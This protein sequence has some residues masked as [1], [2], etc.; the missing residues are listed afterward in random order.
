MSDPLSWI[1]EE[2]SAWRARGLERSLDPKGPSVDGRIWSY[3]RWLVNFASNDYLSL[4]NDPR[5]ALAAVKAVEHDGWGSGSSPLVS[6]WR[7]IHEELASALANLE[8]AQA[9]VLFPT[10]YAANLAAI[11]SLVSRGD[12][13]YSDALN[14]ACIIDAARLSRAEVRI[15]PHSRTDALEE[16]LEADRG[17]FRRILIAVEGVYSMDGDEAH[18]AELAELADRFGAILL[19][20]EAHAT[21]LLG[22]NG[23]IGGVWR[24]GSC[25]RRHAFKGSWFHRRLCRGFAQPDRLADQ[26][27]T[28]ADFFDGSSACS[29][30]R[31][32]SGA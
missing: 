29:V 25:S 8:R 20:D 5:V 27:C 28:I 1:P 26:S 31:C 15:F 10:G 22:E 9:A 21:G 11:T 17:R 18:L 19:V 13:I 4:A 6:G 3:G 23:R 14:H 16:M 7:T 32:S 2:A 30:R 24:K 12:A